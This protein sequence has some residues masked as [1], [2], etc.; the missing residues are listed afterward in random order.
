MSF[1]DI[2]DKIPCVA[3]LYE[4]D[5]VILANNA[6]SEYDKRKG[7][8]PEALPLEFNNLKEKF[9]QSDYVY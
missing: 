6:R 7:N 3:E 5:Y 2:V 9:F 4:S 1:Q 8:A